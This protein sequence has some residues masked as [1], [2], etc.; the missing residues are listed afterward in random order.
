MSED[1]GYA[2]L[3]TERGELVGHA[4][5]SRA[6]PPANIVL[7]ERM[8]IRFLGPRCAYQ[9]VPPPHLES[10][11]NTLIMPCRVPTATADHIQSPDAVEEAKGELLVACT[12]LD[13]RTR[14]W[15]EQASRRILGALG[16]PARYLHA[17]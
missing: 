13:E 11:A 8:F 5:I 17:G 2:P 9:E 7:G 3:Y 10:A 15:M 1:L 16:I 14:D 6:R 12:A 4:P